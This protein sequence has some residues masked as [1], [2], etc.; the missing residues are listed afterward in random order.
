MTTSDQQYLLHVAI[1]TNDLLLLWYGALFKWWDYLCINVDP[2]VQQG[3]QGVI[4]QQE[5]QRVDEH[6]PRDIWL[7]PEAVWFWAVGPN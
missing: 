2:L 4:E 5:D 1:V 7:Q 3:H 6:R